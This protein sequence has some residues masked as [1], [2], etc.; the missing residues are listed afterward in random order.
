MERKTGLSGQFTSVNFHLATVL[1]LVNLSTP[2]LTSS[3]T[4]VLAVVKPTNHWLHEARNRITNVKGFINGYVT[5]LEFLL[6]IA[7]VAGLD[8]GGLNNVH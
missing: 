8:F 7:K 5:K 4:L 3:A 6:E 2:I 1:Q